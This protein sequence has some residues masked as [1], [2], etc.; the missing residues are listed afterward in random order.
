MEAMFLDPQYLSVVGSLIAGGFVLAT[1]IA[2][3]MYGWLHE[4]PSRAAER[5]PL[6]KAA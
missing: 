2:A 4:E 5:E 1:V 3:V 6:K